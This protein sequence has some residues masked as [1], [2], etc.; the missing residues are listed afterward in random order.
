MLEDIE[1]RFCEC[2]K[3][4][5]KGIE[6]F[7]IKKPKD[8]SVQKQ[9]TIKELSDKYGFVPTPLYL[10]DVMIAGRQDEL[11]VDS[12]TCDF[13]AGCGQYTIRLLRYL[14]NKFDIDVENFLTNNHYLTELQP[15]NCAA[16]VYIFGPKINLYVG[17]SMNLKYST[18]QD[19]G[20]VFFNE[21]TKVWEHNKLFDALLT[22]ETFNTN[23]QFLSF[24]F[25]NYKDSNKIVEFVNKIKSGEIELK[26]NEE[27]E[28][29]VEEITVE[30]VPEVIEQIKAQ[31]KPKKIITPKKEK[32]E[33]IKEVT[34]LVVNKNAVVN[35][36]VRFVTV[37]ESGKKEKKNEDMVVSE[38]SIFDI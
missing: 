32:V 25:N 2:T 30:N 35:N 38:A 22:K 14:K 26:K 34:P 19:K 21:K 27:D 1:K 31:D 33:V 28:K 23:K 8:F 20:I 15:E 6:V 9:E 5:N 12:S 4:S 10:V 18:E 3:L 17:D 13:C 29:H 37:A 16:L 11:N 36:D 7:P 24:I